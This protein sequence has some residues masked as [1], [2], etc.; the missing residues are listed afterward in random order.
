MYIRV[1]WYSDSRFE[2]E[3]TLKCDE[4]P[5]KRYHLNNLDR[6]R[7][8]YEENKL[9]CKKY[10]IELLEKKEAKDEQR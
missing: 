5:H 1:S 8:W 6:R 3:R 9:K 10:Y 4:C 2:S 7:K